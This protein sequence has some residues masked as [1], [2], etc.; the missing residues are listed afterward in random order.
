ME[1]SLSGGVLGENHLPK[2]GIDKLYHL[3]LRVECT[4]FVIFKAEREILLK[5]VFKHQKSIQTITK[6]FCLIIKSLN[7]DGEQFQQYQQSNHPSLTTYH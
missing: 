5:V 4:L 6:H 7:T 1:T 2:Q 3:R